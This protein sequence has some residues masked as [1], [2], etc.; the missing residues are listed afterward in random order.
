LPAR[1][2]PHLPWDDGLIRSGEQGQ[3]SHRSVDFE[4][5]LADDGGAAARVRGA[6]P[7][8]NGK[9]GAGPRGLISVCKE[10]ESITSEHLVGMDSD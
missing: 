4:L 3:M 5:L 1:D 10:S 8:K 7:C 6:C 2:A 9:G